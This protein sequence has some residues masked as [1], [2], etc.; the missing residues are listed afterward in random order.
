MVVK[1]TTTAHTKPNRQRQLLEVIADMGTSVI[2]APSPRTDILFQITQYC[3]EMGRETDCGA[4]GFLRQCD[5]LNVHQW[6][7]FAQSVAADE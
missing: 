6:A 7:S 1:P 2:D 3:D 4:K 5:I